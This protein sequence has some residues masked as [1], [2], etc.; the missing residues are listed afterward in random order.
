VFYFFSIDAVVIIVLCEGYCLCACLLMLLICL[1]HG[2]VVQS[3]VTC[4]S[5][6]CL[7]R[8]WTQTVLTVH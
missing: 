8:I 4:D 3:D 2:S 6:E 1:L 5:V 7:H